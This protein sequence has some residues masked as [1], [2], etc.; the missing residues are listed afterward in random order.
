MNNVQKTL[1]EMA[2]DL[3]SVG[4]IDK[5]IL[6]RFDIKSL[7]AV[8]NYRTR[9]LSSNGLKTTDNQDYETR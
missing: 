7:A 1:S 9:F 8:L 4:A 2:K 6:R 3:Y 5:T